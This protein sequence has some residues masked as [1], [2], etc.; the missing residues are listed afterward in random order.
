MIKRTFFLVALFLVSVLLNTAI[1]VQTDSFSITSNAVSGSAQK[2]YFSGLIS[3]GRLDSIYAAKDKDPAN[4]RSFPLQW[5]NIPQGTKTFAL[6][7]DDPDAKPVM[8]TLGIKGD[9]FIHWLAGDIPSTFTGLQD[10]ASQKNPPFVQGKNSLGKI[11]YTGPK[12]PSN[13]PKDA[14]KPIIHIYRVTLYA[15]NAPTGLKD[16][17]DLEQFKAAV[18]GKILA[19]AKMNVS[20]SN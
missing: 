17:F 11:G 4:A 5:K 20:Y 3:V 19:E 9:A 12:P 14:Q 16:G 2:G 8:E 10:D 15:L 13:I 1:S 6:L 18:K 7:I